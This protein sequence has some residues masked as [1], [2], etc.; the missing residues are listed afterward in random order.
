[1]SDD[2]TPDSPGRRKPSDEGHGVADV[3]VLERTAVDTDGLITIETSDVTAWCPYEG[4][5]DYYTVC[6]EYSPDEYAL[7]LMS[8]RDYLQTFRDEEIGHEEFAQR[9]FEDL[10]SLLDPKWLRLTVEAPP[11]YGLNVTLRHQTGSKPQ[12]LT[13]TATTAQNSSGSRHPN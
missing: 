10:V 11:R 6:I 8:Y 13:E 12:S 2:P 4:T 3:P 7:E 1:M 9:V 5:A